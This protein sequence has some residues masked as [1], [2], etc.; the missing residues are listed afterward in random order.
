VE[1]ADL[2]ALQLLAQFLPVRPARIPVPAEL[3]LV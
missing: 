3:A 1:F 2:N